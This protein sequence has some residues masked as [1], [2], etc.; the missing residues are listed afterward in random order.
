MDGMKSLDASYA[1]TEHLTYLLKQRAIDLKAQSHQRDARS[2]HRKMQNMACASNFC[3]NLE[4]AS[5][6]TT[7]AQRVSSALDVCSAHE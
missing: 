4:E 2:A 7:H 5:E 3:Q 6:L 1:R